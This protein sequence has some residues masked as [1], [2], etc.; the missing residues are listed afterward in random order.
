MG[1]DGE[2]ITDV[3]YQLKLPDGSV[4]EGTLEAD[5]LI[6]VEGIDAGQCE[7]SFPDLDQDAWVPA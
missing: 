1:E 6:R 3:R 7:L 2:P 4:Q 5:G